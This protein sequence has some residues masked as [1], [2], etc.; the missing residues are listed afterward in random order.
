VILSVVG[1]KGGL[2]KTTT[3]V[4][5][6]VAL[7]RDGQRVLLL[8]MDPQANASA[9]FGVRN[10]AL[11]IFDALVDA[12]TVALQEVVQP[13]EA[14]PMLAPGAR[15]M[16]GL[17][18]A[19]RDQPGR[20]LILR[21]ALETVADDYDFIITDN[22]STLGLSVSISL[23]ASDLAII[24]LICERLALE[25]LSQTLKTIET[26]KRRLNPR[27]ERR[28]LLSNVDERYSDGKAIAADVRAALGS[29]VLSSTV[30]T[31]ATLKKGAPVFDLDANGNAA[32]DYNALANEMLILK[33]KFT[34]ATP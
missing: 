7:V 29:I 16:A 2:G 9:L 11:S 1:E 5:L 4:N 19:L 33:D 10:P 14:G 31:S 20:E 8:D 6:A 26:L 17:D 3:A 24:P 15:A 13:T 21:E 30:A 28:L 12:D 34:N 18:S 23:C 32:K 22:A 27:I 25:G